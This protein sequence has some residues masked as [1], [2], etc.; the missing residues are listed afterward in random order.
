MKCPYCGKAETDVLDTRDTEDLTATR[1]RRSC[2]HCTKRFTTYERIEHVPLIVLKKDGR[3][4]SFDRTKVRLGII[5]ACEKRT[6]PIQEIDKIVDAIE[7]DLRQMDST[8]INSQVIGN[9][10][11]DRL[12]KLDKIAYIRFASVY[13]QFADIDDFAKALKTLSQHPKKS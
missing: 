12:K 8:E 7:L 5:K 10:V 9:M 13:R 4:E 1:R 11:M 3:R 6:I 2:R